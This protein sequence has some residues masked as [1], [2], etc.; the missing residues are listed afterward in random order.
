MDNA[1]S[2][3]SDHG[4]GEHHVFSDK[5]LKRTFIILCSLTVLTVMLALIER[6]YGV[7]FGLRFSV[8]HIEFGWLSVP[9]ALGIAGMKSYFVAANFMGLRQ[10]KG[11]NLLVFVGSLVFLVIFFGFTYLDF[12]FRDT[13]EALSITPKD[14]QQEQALEAE[15][16]YEAIQEQLLDA[17]F[18]QDAD[19]T[20]FSVPPSAAPAP[21]APADN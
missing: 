9:L 10:D 11:T 3:S 1:S 21:E 2:A 19:P 13:F 16:G 7:A 4:H 8:P 17:P 15:K 18:V 20:L 14:V 6:G 12:H 5:M